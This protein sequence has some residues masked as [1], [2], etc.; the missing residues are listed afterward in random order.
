MLIGI[1]GGNGLLGKI[2][3]K[4]IQ[5]PNL[6]DCFCGDI[7]NKNEIFQWIRGKKFDVI[8]HFAARVPVDVVAEDPFEA[9]YVNAAGTMNL[10]SCLREMKQTPWLLYASTSHVYK[11]SYYPISEQDPIEPQNIYGES[12]FHGERACE[13]FKHSCSS[14][15]CIARIFSFYHKEQK[16]PFLYPSIKK[17]LE[18]EDLT[19]PFF[20]KGAK[21]IRDIQNAEEVVDQ[22]L[23]LMQVRFDGIINIG[24]GQGIEIE[25]FVRS[26]SPKPLKI[27]CDLQEPISY[28]VA[29]ISKFKEVAL[30]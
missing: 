26:I 17:R 8:F 2:L 3:Q 10:L 25:E 30:K 29:D 22:L 27:T 11:S 13:M 7:R 21:N 18:T 24:S 16:P 28:L 15:V 1:T 5:N 23:Q 6:V 9:F 12:K 14:P 20:L 4:K 19:K